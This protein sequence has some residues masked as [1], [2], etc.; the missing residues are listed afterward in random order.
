MIPLRLRAFAPRRFHARGSLH[1][2]H[3]G[4]AFFKLSCCRGGHLLVHARCKKILSKLTHQVHRELK[5]P[6][7]P[8]NG[9]TVLR[10]PEEI[11]PR[12]IPQYNLALLELPEDFEMLRRNPGGTHAQWAAAI[13][14]TIGHKRVIYPRRDA[15]DKDHY[16]ITARG[17]TYRFLAPVG[18]QAMTVA[19]KRTLL[20]VLAH[21]QIFGPTELRRPAAADAERAAVDE[22]IWRR[23]ERSGGTPPPAHPRR[24][25]RGRVVG[26]DQEA[27]HQVTVDELSHVVDYRDN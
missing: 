7:C 11:D 19:E 18:N 3:S 8:L 12:H 13:A 17:M 14:N 23:G 9:E 2:V 1:D 27:D 22:Q 5:E 26:A 21:M 10:E 25:G 15:P 24:E 4:Q 20:N 6:L 16:R